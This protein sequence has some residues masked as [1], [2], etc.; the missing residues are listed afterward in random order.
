MQILEPAAESVSLA[1]LAIVDGFE[2]NVSGKRGLRVGIDA[3]IWFQHAMASKVG[4]NPEIRC[5]LFKLFN[6]SEMP[7]IPLFM[8]DGRQRPT[9]KRGSK[10]GKSG[11]HNL[12]KKMKEMLD[13]CGMEW[14]VV[15]VCPS[16]SESN[17]HR[18]RTRL[19]EKQKR[20]WLISATSA[21][22]TR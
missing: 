8:F 12:S 15:R 22:W 2:K 1:K 14:R 5:L 13:I 18:V 20:N 17:V 10:K 7:I 3:S 16:S 9:L 19:Q 4:A 6:L 21:C 11:S